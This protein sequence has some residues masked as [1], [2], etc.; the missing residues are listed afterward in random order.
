MN[1][2]IL[3]CTLRDGGFVN[4]WDFGSTN[5]PKIIQH[6]VDANI[7][8]VECGFIADK[9]HNKDKTYYNNFEQLAPYLPKDTKNSCIVGLVNSGTLT[10]A[11]LPD[12]TD[13]RYVLRI[14]FRSTQIEQA[15]EEAKQ[16]KRKGY[17]VFLNPMSTNNYSDE[18]LT[19]LIKKVNEVNPYGMAL[20][21]TTGTMTVE[22]VTKFYKLMDDNLNPNIAF[23]YHSHNNLQLSY[24]NAQEFIR[25]ES[26][27]ELIIDT[28]A[29]GMG[30]GAGNLGT[31]LFAKYLNDYQNANYNIIKILSIIDEHI[32]KIYEKT[33]W[34]YCVPYYIAA[35]NK[36]HP[37]YVEFLEEKG[38]LSVDKISSLLENIPK[39]NRIRYKKEIIE[40]LYTKLVK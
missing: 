36:C 4:E 34:G 26:K 27:R 12:T 31:E 18:D 15:L 10:I 14:V 24:A 6:L 30:R 20:V 8:Y 5:I 1:I 35:V 11:N 3:D 37:N 2:K 38:G 33:P 21:D 22:D 28:T 40:D 32:K 23:G 13:P 17:K 25:R 9:E 16:L 7:D 19:N 29:M 39:E